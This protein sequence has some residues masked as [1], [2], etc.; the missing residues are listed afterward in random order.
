MLVGSDLVFCGT[1]LTI[2]ALIPE[3]IT[4]QRPVQR[5]VQRLVQSRYRNRY[6]GRDRGKCRDRAQRRYQSRDRRNQCW[7]TLDLVSNFELL[8]ARLEYIY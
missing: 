2:E 5:P 6:Q 4:E 3:K 7:G 1:V 8:F